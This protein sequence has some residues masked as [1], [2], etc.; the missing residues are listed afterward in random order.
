MEPTWDNTVMDN[1]HS[2]D[3]PPGPFACIAVDATHRVAS[4]RVEPERAVP[5]TG[6]APIETP[7][8]VTVI[9]ADAGSFDGAIWES[10]G[11]L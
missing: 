11:S 9:E 1:A 5:E 4:G 3:T 6:A 8:T 2:M 7:T 10:A